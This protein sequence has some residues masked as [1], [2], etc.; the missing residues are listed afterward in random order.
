M[1]VGFETNLRSLLPPYITSSALVV[2]G[3][4][5]HLFYQSHANKSMFLTTLTILILTTELSTCITVNLTH[6]FER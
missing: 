5:A 2:V 6:T 3:S 4:L 1:L